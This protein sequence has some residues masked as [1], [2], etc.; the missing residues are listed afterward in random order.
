[1]PPEKSGAPQDR[2]TYYYLDEPRSSL[3]ESE[4]NSTISYPIPHYRSLE[5]LHQSS[6]LP[7]RE[8]PLQISP[9]IQRFGLAL[10]LG[11]VGCGGAESVTPPSAAPQPLPAY[12][13]QA[14][15][16]FDDRIDP[17]AVGL[18]DVASKPRTDPVLRARAQTAEVVAR[19]RVATVSVD[20][21]AGKP[22]YRLSL[23]L[24]G[25]FLVRRGFTDDRVEISV[26]PD[27]P[28]FGVVK[29]LDTRLIGHTFIGFFH[30]YAGVEDVEL[31]FHLSADN[32][33]VLAAV[34]EAVTL[35]EISGK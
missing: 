19:A 11:S 25:G 9:L 2:G 1:M 29:W 32:P 14:T 6:T 13:G 5:D 7:P 8:L 21:A 15:T 27:S 34:R 17:G 33:E 30:H 10:L 16:L 28:A 18:A 3:M 20:S 23:D 12:R 4:S 22:I 35:R 26:R 31:K 24:A